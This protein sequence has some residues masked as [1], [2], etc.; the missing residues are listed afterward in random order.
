MWYM[1]EKTKTLGSIYCE[2][3]LEELQLEGT[4]LVP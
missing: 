3:K 4:I 2:E 1:H